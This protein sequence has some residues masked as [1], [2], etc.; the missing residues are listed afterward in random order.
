MNCAPITAVGGK[1]TRLERFKAADTKEKRGLSDLPAVFLE[2]LG[3]VTGTCKVNKGL[4]QAVKYPEPGSVVSHPEGTE[5]LL[6]PNCNG[7][8]HAGSRS[9]AKG[10]PD[11][12]AESADGKPTVVPEVNY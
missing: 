2:G 10:T 12:V 1:Q 3:D 8:R 7:N 4:Q 5:K 6:S 9:N 11:P